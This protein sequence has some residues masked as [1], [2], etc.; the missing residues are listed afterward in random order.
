VL[1]ALALVGII[2]ALGLVGCGEGGSHDRGQ[3]AGPL[4]PFGPDAAPPSTTLAVCPQGA[5]YATIGAAVAAA[6]EGA[7]IEVC[8]GTYKE[9]VVIAGKSLFLVGTGG[10]AMTIIDGVS[11]GTPLTVTATHD[12]LVTV[13]GFTLEHGSASGLRCDGSKLRVR[14]STLNDNRG[15]GGGGLAANG[16][17]IEVDRVVFTRNE[18]SPRG[19]GALF[20]NSQGAVH[21]SRFEGNSADD[22]GG[23]A[24]VEGRLAITDNTFSANTAR[25][26]GGGIYHESSS[27]IAR[28]TIADNHADWTSGGVHVVMHAPTLH[29]N[30]VRGNSS[31]NDGGGIYL[32]QSTATLSHNQVL[33][34]HCGDDGGGIRVFTSHARLEANLVADNLADDCGGGIRV[35]H[36]ASTLVDNV[37]R[38]NR[39]SNTGGGLDLDNDSS[40]VQGGEV[41]G[42]HASRGGGIF[43]WMAPWDGGLIENVEL[44]DNAA[45]HG[46][47]I[48]LDDNFQPLTLRGLT[49]TGNT[50]DRGAGLYL[51]TTA[52]TLSHSIFVD[53]QASDQGGAIYAGAPGDFGMECPCPPTNP[54]SEIAFVV[55]HGNRAPEGAAVFTSFGDLTVTSSIFA[56]NDGT[57]VTA[58]GPDD[59]PGQVAV[60]TWQYNDVYPASFA[61]MVAAGQN[62]NL[63]VDP[64]FMAPETGNFHLRSGSPCVDAGDPARHD[65]DGSRADMGYF[66]GSP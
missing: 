46:G 5:A 60:P 38:G 35:S 9:R 41:S 65:A 13:E 51:R 47:A 17:T 66:G 57:Q 43:M 31:V 8:P 21:D 52:L 2:G 1:P 18:G 4:D 24:D 61:G 54:H 7:A 42:N 44:A 49:I 29:D 23:L 14:A 58:A 6:P 11:A 32:D 40:V 27:E 12:A 28:N 37:V 59:A 16:C 25:V 63:A 19:G 10:A 62:G 64:M 34:N 26:R 48:A 53:N 50:A 39:A 55:A 56:G 20:V 33:K 36:L 15:Q 30:V 22:G 45:W 3:D